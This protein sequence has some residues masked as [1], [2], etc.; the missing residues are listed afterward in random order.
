[1]RHSRT[2]AKKISPIDLEMTRPAEAD[3]VVPVAL[4]R[5]EDRAMNLVVGV[6][7][8][9]STMAFTVAAKSELPG[10]GLNVDCATA[11]G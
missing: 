4:V 7:H 2:A 6:R 11:R 10:N 5:S 9:H 8:H 3:R 1:M